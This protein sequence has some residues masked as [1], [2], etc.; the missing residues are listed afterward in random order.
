LTTNPAQNPLDF[1]A[2]SHTG[3]PDLIV[4]THEVIRQQDGPNTLFYLD[5]P[6]LHSTGASTD[7]Y[8]PHEMTEADH[9]QLLALLGTLKGKVMLSGYPSDLYEQALVGW[10]RHT[11]DMANNAASGKTKARETEVLWCK[12]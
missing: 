1:S 4:K 8:G 6:Y 12:F 3:Y 5:P 7:T 10:T 11:F 2:F 9:R